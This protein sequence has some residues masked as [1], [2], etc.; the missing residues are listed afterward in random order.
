MSL[1]ERI[2]PAE[3]PGRAA[4]K[5][6]AKPMEELSPPPIEPATSVIV[7]LWRQRQDLATAANRLDLQC[8]ALCRRASDG[9][10]DAAGALWRLIREGKGENAALSLV[11]IP[12]LTALAELESHRAALEKQ[13][14]RRAREL[15]LWTNWGAD[16][17]GIGPLLIAGLV[18][19]AGRPLSDYR[20]VSALWKRFGLAVLDGRRQ[21]RI[22]G[23]AARHGYS[24]RRRA[25]A[26]V[27]ATS[28]MRSQREGDPYR[29]I[30]DKRKA[31]ELGRGLPK[32]HAH[33]RALR[34]MTKALLCDAWAAATGAA[35]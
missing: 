3:N 9:D 6:P 30:Y 14:E 13:I 11:L 7:D 5:E 19:E 8:Q 15:E 34:V 33:N 26:Y 21:R 12:Y 27:V 32:G 29:T 23:E 31:Y 35:T 2:D 24:P 1:A 20:S 16:V 17:R 4:T 28:L 10:K 22:A 18:G 25:F